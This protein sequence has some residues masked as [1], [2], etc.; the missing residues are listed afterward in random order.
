MLL[1]F[2]SIM[3]MCAQV[4][5]G[6]DESS[7]EGSLLQLK[8]K[9][10]IIDDGVNASKGFNL[11]RVNLT[12]AANLFPMFLTDPDISTSGASP[13]Y[14][15]NKATLDLTH[16]GLM[17]YNINATAPF[18]QGVYIWNGA[19]W[20]L[21]GGNEP[22]R[23]SG[24]TNEAVSNTENIYQ[25]GQVAIGTAAAADPTAILNVVATNKGVLL[26]RV[27]LTS[28]TDATTIP[29]PTTGLL[30]YNTGTSGTF[31]T[32]GYMYWNGTAWKMF[33]STSSEA[34][35]ATLNCSSASMSPAQQIAGNTAIIAGTVLQIPY[36][37]SN[38][39]SYNGATLVST[40][41]SGVTAVASDNIL[42]V[43]NGVISFALSGIPTTSQEAPNGLVFDLTPFLSANPG[44]IGCSQV[45]VGNT[46]SASIEETAVM[47][48]L[49][50]AVDNTGND[51]GTAGYTLSCTSPDG[52]YS[53]RV[54][55]P[56]NQTSIALGSQYINIQL[57][58]NQN[59]AQTVIW[60][61]NTIYSGGTVAGANT[62]TM[63]A[64]RWGGNN[65]DSGNTWYNAT[66]GTTSY[67]GYMGNIGIYDGNGPEYRRY[68]WIPLG[69]T[70]NVSYEIFVMAALDTATP[71][72]AVSPTQMK[73][74]IRFI[75]VT[76]AQ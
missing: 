48:Y 4:T 67:G 11:P 16:K 64:Q 21:A 75:Q 32:V 71:S 53:A 56:N 61:Y 69:A 46:L 15:A 57:R 58:N 55:V 39:G 1:N 34:A 35:T 62:L 20:V 2:F 63:P 51:T 30:V 33:A 42:S 52:K 19:K 43:G 9:I 18:V 13:V 66:A 29:N 27:A 24:S 73:V 6:A 36:T 59:T 38:G 31:S 65:S 54:R 41:N 50:L 70:N 3:F 37:G 68:T 40:T 7:V 60:N 23:V 26:P 47:G 8:D 44:I 74:Y 10:G 45:V 5:I 14:T 76:A 25:M 12:D 17:V 49:K 28:S 22:W 72:I